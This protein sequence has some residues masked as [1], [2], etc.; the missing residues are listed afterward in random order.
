M[1]YVFYSGE[2]KVIKIYNDG[3]KLDIV[4]IKKYFN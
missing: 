1:N 4:D 3:N 2:S